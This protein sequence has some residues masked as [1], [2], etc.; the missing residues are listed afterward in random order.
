MSETCF[1]FGGCRSGKSRYALEIAEQAVGKKYFIATL[2]PG[3]D[4]MKERI[5]R[6]QE[7][8]GESWK[9]VEEPVDIEEAVE[10]AAG[11]ADCII[12]DCLTLW[13]S[14]MMMNEFTEEQILAKADLLCEVLNKASCTIA[15][16]SNEVGT[17]VVPE[18]RL[19]RD[20]R[21]YTGI[22]NQKIAAACDR[23]VLMKA[24]IPLVI[25]GNSESGNGK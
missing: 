8:R 13:I 5:R 2:Q 4:E 10:K 23:V 3:D 18:S 17:G 24:G 9:T 11:T 12:V 20:F 25:K 19:G 7:E 1:V 15:L 22:I 14:N 6:H 16:V 21:D